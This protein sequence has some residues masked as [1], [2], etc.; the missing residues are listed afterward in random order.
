VATLYTLNH[1]NPKNLIEIKKSDLNQFKKIMIFINPGNRIN[2]ECKEKFSDV[3]NQTTSKSDF[4]EQTD[5]NF[6]QSR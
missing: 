2:I 1:K 3:I 5:C 4:V 6:C